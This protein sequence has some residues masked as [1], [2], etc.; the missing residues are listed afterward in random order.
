MGKRILVIED[1][2]DN[3]TLI[4]DLLSSFDYEIFQAFDGEAGVEMV[5][6]TNPHLILMDL[7]L[8]RMDG[9]TAVQMIKAK[10]EYK[11]IP[12]I[13]LTAHALTGDKERALAAGCN[14]YLTKPLEFTQ[15]LK[16]LATYLDS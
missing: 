3:M 13:A 12:V 16:K 9:W 4:V 5:T 1:N 14:D 6:Q 2:R 8:P 11:D 7:S 15:L 10:P